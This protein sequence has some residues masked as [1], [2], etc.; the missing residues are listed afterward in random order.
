MKIVTLSPDRHQSTGGKEVLLFLPFFFIII[1]R[2]HFCLFFMRSKRPERGIMQIRSYHP[3]DC[4]ETARLF[5]ETVHT[6]CI[7]HYTEEQRCAWAPSN[8]DLIKWNASFLKHYALVAVENG[9]IAGFGDISDAGHLDRL[10][11][12]RSF[13][14]R[15][16]AGKLCD[17]LEQ[18]YPVAKITT[19]AS[20]TAKPFFEK[21]GYRTVR[22]QQVER[23]GILL[24]NYAMEKENSR[25][26]VK[27]RVKSHSD[28]AKEI[29]Q[30]GEKDTTGNRSVCK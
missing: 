8:P 15:G 28:R 25:S 24:T 6:V 5:Y 23:N 9:I 17:L 20:I 13:Q 16:I 7:Q 30:Y 12:H 14:R 21:R 27:H 4:R 2:N 10:Y 26:T 29:Q 11:V 1:R 3:N 18:Q 22:E 19:H